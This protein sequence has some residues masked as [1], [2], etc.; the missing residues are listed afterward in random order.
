MSPSGGS[1]LI[2]SA[3]RSANSTPQYG[4]ASMWPT[5]MMRMPSRGRLTHDSCTRPPR[6]LPG[7]NGNDVGERHVGVEDGAYAELLQ[8]LVILGGGRPP[9]QKRHGPP[10]PRLQ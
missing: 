4:P 5:S 10:L 2:T 9:Y 8:R 1:T 7:E 6:N 3:P